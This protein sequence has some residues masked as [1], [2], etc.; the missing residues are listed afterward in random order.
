MAGPYSQFG[1]CCCTPVEA[2]GEMDLYQNTLVPTRSSSLIKFSRA[3]SNTTAAFAQN[4]RQ[5][6]SQ[7]S[8]ARPAPD[9]QRFISQSIASWDGSS[10]FQLEG[11]QPFFQDANIAGLATIN[12][13]N[14]TTYPWYD[15]DGSGYTVLSTDPLN[16]LVSFSLLRNNCNITTAF[17]FPGFFGNVALGFVLRLVD[18]N[19]YLRVR[20]NFNFQPLVFVLERVVAGVAT[21]LASTPL[22]TSGF[23]NSYTATVTCNNSA[24]SA[25]INSVDQ[26]NNPHSATVSATTTQFQTATK[27][28]F[29]LTQTI[30][31]GTLTPV[32][33]DS[34]LCQ[35]TNAA[36][37]F[38]GCYSTAPA[39]NGS[40]NDDVPTGYGG[41]LVVGNGVA[42]QE[43]GYIPYIPNNGAILFTPP[44]D[45]GFGNGQV[46]NA[47]G[48]GFG[49][50]YIP[51]ISDNPGH[52]G[53]IGGYFW[54]GRE[55]STAAH[56]TPKSMLVGKSEVWTPAGKDNNGNSLPERQNTLSQLGKEVIGTLPHYGY[57]NC[58]GFILD[59]VEL[60]QAVDRIYI[61]GVDPVNNPGKSILAGDYWVVRGTFKAIAGP[62]VDGG[63]TGFGF[64]KINYAP[65]TSASLVI[66]QWTIETL[67]R[68]S[69]GPNIDA[70]TPPPPIPPTENDMRLGAIA[71]SQ[72]EGIP[73]APGSW[74]CNPSMSVWCCRLGINSYAM[75][76]DALDIL[77]YYIPD[78]NGFNPGPGFYG[79]GPRF[80][81]QPYTYWQ[82]TTVTPSA[83]SNG[84]L[85]TGSIPAF[86]TIGPDTLYLRAVAGLGQEVMSQIQGGFDF[87][88]YGHGML[89]GGANVAS[90]RYWYCGINFDSEASAYAFSTSDLTIPKNQIIPAGQ[91]GAGFP[92]PPSLKDCYWRMDKG[93]T[94]RTPLL[95]VDQFGQYYARDTIPSTTPGTLT[96]Q[97]GD[98]TQALQGWP[99]GDCIK[100]SDKL[101]P[102]LANPVF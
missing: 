40:L 23:D 7:W 80:L 85:P 13:R 12:N 43:A 45:S 83:T 27:F 6:E 57:P 18:A 28:G 58:C 4:G 59:K 33:I 96:I 24:I 101:A 81:V 67:V 69:P 73:N 97:G 47:D 52:A 79:Y 2:P 44:S 88:N 89:S 10:V 26:F 11:C 90:D 93:G 78:S 74:D 17:R 75:K 60:V 41:F 86:C 70:N 29:W 100:S 53:P 32:A 35:S 30:Q 49:S 38:V 68:T 77:Q 9:Q 61:V 21:T 63:S 92:N 71:F 16:Q 64:S 98:N 19:N 51:M 102:A 36:K 65:H 14:A 62:L 34:Y 46:S 99:A 72:S 42:Y 3:C 25:T 82:T 15:P 39:H 54:G 31:T 1:A 56:A 95:A 55:I 84:P 50:G 8:A 5:I 20:I 66:G 37:T 48:I 87:L 22:I 94:I 76:P 91:P